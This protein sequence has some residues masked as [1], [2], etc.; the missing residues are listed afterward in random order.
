MRR[1]A[2]PAAWCPAHRRPQGRPRAWVL[3]PLSPE[4]DAGA[5]VPSPRPAVPLRVESESVCAAWVC[6][7]QSGEPGLGPELMGCGS[8]RLGAAAG[9]G[10]GRADAPCPLLSPESKRGLVGWIVVRGC[11]INSK[12]GRPRRD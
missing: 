10:P 6:R 3:P 1:R 7:G 9:V 8:D 12:N 5:Q 4:P 11:V 2:E